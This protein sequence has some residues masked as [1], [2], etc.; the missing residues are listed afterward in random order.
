MG[1]RAGRARAGK[2]RRRGGRGGATR[3]PHPETTCAQQEGPGR[4]WAAGAL[5]LRSERGPSRAP[6]P[7]P[8]RW[9]EP[10]GLRDHEERAGAQGRRRLR[11]PRRWTQVHLAAG[12]GRR[13]RR[14][15]G[16]RG[17]SGVGGSEGGRG[18][19]GNR[20][21]FGAGSIRGTGGPA[22]PRL[23]RPREPLR[24]RFVAAAPARQVE[25]PAWRVPGRTFG[26]APRSPPPALSPTP[27][28][29]LEVGSSRHLVIST[30][31]V[32]LGK[33]AAAQ[34]VSGGLG[35]GGKFPGGSSVLE[36]LASAGIYSCLTGQKAS[37]PP[38]Q[39]ATGSPELRLP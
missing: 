7:A 39:R 3:E 25:F 12:G 9:L 29:G 21:V 22:A 36:S 13:A 35:R 24:C 11:C 5:G 8:R 15:G 18:W 23:S 32:P 14:R 26:S 30:L 38:G 17:G 34:A 19:P 20:G 1:A 33:E 28:P 2:V 16:T 10:H 6:A 37:E 27:T 31:S 4:A